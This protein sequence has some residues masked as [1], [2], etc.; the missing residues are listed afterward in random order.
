MRLRTNKLV[1]A[2][3]RLLKK[4]LATMLADAPGANS[5]PKKSMG[6]VHSALSDALKQ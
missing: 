5:T 3:R 4:R 6:V 1:R 2:S